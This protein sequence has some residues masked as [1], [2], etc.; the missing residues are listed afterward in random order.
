MRKQSFVK[1]VKPNLCKVIERVQEAGQK[2]APILPV[3][4]LPPVT[5]EQ[6]GYIP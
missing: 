1:E 3:T 5:S 6:G 2:T 4:T